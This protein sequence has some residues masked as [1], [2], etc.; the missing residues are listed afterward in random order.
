[1]T[2]VNCDKNLCVYCRFGI[3]ELDRIHLITRGNYRECLEFRQ[4][5]LY[6]PLGKK[7]RVDRK[8]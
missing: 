4:R 5:E 1:V 7:L 2:E 3:C 8:G 6:D